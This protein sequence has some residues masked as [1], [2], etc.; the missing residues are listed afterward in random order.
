[1]ECPVCKIT[2]PKKKKHSQCTNCNADLEVYDLIAGIEEK[3]SGQKSTI[4]ILTMM[5]LLFVGAM[6]AYYF[7]FSKPPLQNN[8]Q[9]STDLIKQQ[10]AE[11]QQL[12]TEKTILMQSI[13]D[14]QARLEA[15]SGQP[16][17]SVISRPTPLQPDTPNINTN[18]PRVQTPTPTPPVVTPV[19]TPAQV[20][21]R[22][23]VV[24]RGETLRQIAE[25]Y[26][27]NPDAFTRIMAD[28]NIKNPDQITVGQRLKIILP[29]L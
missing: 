1:M 20:S 18:I 16:A 11:I 12:Q 7:Y 24:R 21:E 29:N 27:G 26:Y 8:L 3:V 15:A 9:V 23:H 2:L 14:L 10:Q 22:I 19:V 13:I 28:N 25:I 5:L 17:T 6:A 4:F